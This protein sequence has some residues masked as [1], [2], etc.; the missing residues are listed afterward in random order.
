MPKIVDSFKVGD[1]LIIIL[2]TIEKDFRKIKINGVLYDVTIPYDIPNGI[3][4]EADGFL[5]GQTVELV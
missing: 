3:A 5:V 2:D 1:F 4:I